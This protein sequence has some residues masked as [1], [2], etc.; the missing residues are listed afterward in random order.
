[1]LLTGKYVLEDGTEADVSLR[2]N[3]TL[4]LS[5]PEQPDYELVPYR[6]MTFLIKNLQGFSV[7]FEAGDSGQV[8]GLRFIQP[9]GEFPAVRK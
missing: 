9:N 3:R 5:L 7:R 2:G 1:A 8:K 4:W 6:E